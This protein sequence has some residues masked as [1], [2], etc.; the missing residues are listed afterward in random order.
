MPRDGDLKSDGGSP[1]S[2]LDPSPFEEPSHRRHENRAAAYGAVVVVLIA[3]A[4]PVHASSWSSAWGLQTIVGVVATILA[5]AIGALALVGFYSRQRG[6]YLYIGTG[7]LGTGVLEAYHALMTSPIV[8]GYFAQTPAELVDL[9]A[10]S[11]T[12]SRLFLS[13][14]IYVSWLAWR[15][16]RWAK[17]RLQSPERA[18]YVTASL[19]TLTILVFFTI[20]LASGAHFPDFFVHRP[21]EFIPAFFFIL[22]FGGYWNKAAWKEDP[23]EHWLL[24]ALAISAVTHAVY[25]PFSSGLYDALYDASGLL[26]VLSYLAVLVGLLSSVYDT[27][28]REEQ[29]FVQVRRANEALGREV[30]VRR[31]AERVLQQSEMRLQDFLENANDLIQSTAPD[32]TILYVNRAWKETLGYTNEQ[33]RGLKI[34][35]V[36]HPVRRE[37]YAAELGRCLNGDR[38]SNQEV[39]FLASDLQVV[40][41]SGAS[42]CR[43]VDGEPVAIQSIYRDVTKQKR[44]EQQLKTSQ[45]N[46]QALIENTG[47]VIW[48][49][50]KDHR[51]ITFNAAF[52]L[53]VEARTGR[54]PKRGDPPELAFRP[55]AA[56]RFR[57][58]YTRALSGERFTQLRETEVNGYTS[59]YEH[60]FNPIQE[61]VGVTGVVIFGKD[62]T[63]RIQAEAALVMAKE[64][65]ESANRAKS[66]FLANMSHELRTPLN[67]VIG[68][69]N[70]LLKNKDGT[71]EERQKGFL[72]RILVNGRHLLGL[73]NEVLDL[74]K[75]ESGRLEAEV[76]EVDLEEL[77]NE[78]ILQLDGQVRQ[79]DIQ[80]RADVARGINPVETDRGKLKQVIINL[81]GN[82]IKFTQ[83]GEVVI[84]VVASEDGETPKAI[85]VVDSGIGIPKDRLTAIFEAF[86]QA[87][88]STSRRFGGT[89]LGLT[90]SRS[91]CLLLGFDLV[92][93]SIEGEGSTFTILLHAAADRP[94]DHAKDG[95]TDEEPAEAEAR[96][97]AAVGGNPQR[98]ESPELPS[99]ATVPRDQAQSDS[100]RQQHEAPPRV[101]I[102]DDQ[103]DARVMLSEALEDFGCEIL[104]AASAEEGLDLARERQPHLI[105]LDLHMPGMGGWEALKEIK[106]DPDLSA[107]PVVVV[108]VEGGRGSGEFLGAVDMLDKPVERED[109]LRVISRN[110]NAGGNR[111]ILVVD[112]DADV[113]AVLDEELTAAGYQVFQAANGLEALRQVERVRPATILLD[114]LMPVMDGYGF[115]QRLR[116][117]PRNLKIPVIIVTAKDL[118]LEDRRVLEAASCGILQKGDVIEVKLQEILK[119][120][121]SAAKV[122]MVGSGAPGAS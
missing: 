115:L 51:L 101:L 61:G 67:S 25:I 56:R 37:Q 20:T 60:F 57:E 44:A 103:D 114:L 47:D 66:Q 16:E 55:A 33:L 85:A 2:S 108:S 10:W 92:V 24:I 87:D 45:A 91:I 99:V 9:S 102:I 96:V 104:T 7:F 39:E 79:K 32:G 8:S 70:I 76:T 49:V 111:R 95:S 98:V 34:F 3:A 48:S 53:A 75:I 52:S 89:G 64:E 77:V 78:T 43:M 50:D 28:R 116:E 68:F 93:D 118:T 82:A 21:A 11:W 105:T 72:E 119:G 38:I 54:E 100:S 15:K 80:L 26:K 13:L 69:A 30:S 6:I 94:E 18:V 1:Q 31:E 106:A 17:G 40:V 112:D 83:E 23:F 84:R 90:I 29:V 117:H 14:F 12:A 62:V 122:E 35:D 110:L 86:Q 113:R 71:L 19:L 46:L 58:A 74:A 120:L 63:R 121:L 73:I 97:A 88:S 4:V 22:G 27:F 81:V 5:F 107:I 109:L 36:I 42:N 41:C 59:H 65:A